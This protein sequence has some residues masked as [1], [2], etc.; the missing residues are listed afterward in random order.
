MLNRVEATQITGADRR[1]V[2]SATVLI[3]PTLP[4]N[5]W[6]FAVDVDTD[7]KSF[8]KLVQKVEEEFKKEKRWP[9]WITGPHDEP[10][11]V[12]NRLRALGYV[13]DPDRTVMYIDK[14]PKLTVEAPEGLEIERAEDETVDECV[15]IAV[16]RFGWSY[17]WAKSLRA[18][19]QNGIARGPNHYRM[20]YAN[21]NGAGVAT[22]FTVFFA[23]TA[24][25]YGMATSKDFE[26]KGIGRVLF[27]HAV[28]EAFVRG[29]DVLTL[30]A[31]TGSKAE[32]F[33]EKA[34]LQKAYIARKIVKSS[35]A[36]GR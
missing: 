34:G 22:A 19:A 31:P 12:E 17:E 11:D 10:A 7:E 15:Q 3:H 30:Q 14:K 2:D 16:Q 8:E 21:L 20:Y 35:G 23:G 5:S 24:G 25:I 32:A 13:A 36:R 26:G 1:E 9:A 33:Y 4:A 27:N 28:E 18:A 29:V 6:N